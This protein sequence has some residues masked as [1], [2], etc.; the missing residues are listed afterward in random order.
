MH[1]YVTSLSQNKAST[2]A[3]C[4][5]VDSHNKG[6]HRLRNFVTFVAKGRNKAAKF[7]PLCARRYGIFS[8]YLVSMK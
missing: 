5:V 7:T 6:K 1:F 2:L 8:Y 4:I 3:W